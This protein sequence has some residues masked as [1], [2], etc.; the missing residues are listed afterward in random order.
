MNSSELL[1]GVADNRYIEGANSLADPDL[2]ALTCV[3]LTEALETNWPTDA[4]LVCYQLV[5]STAWPRCNKPVLPSIRAAGADLIVPILVFDYDNPNHSDW[6]LGLLE[7]FELRMVEAADFGMPLAMGWTHLYF[8]KHGARLIYVLDH[9]VLA[10]DAEALSL[11]VIRDF[12]AHGIA[13]DSA[14]ADWTRLFRLPRVVRDGEETGSADYFQMVHQAGN[15]LDPASVI[16]GE[17]TAATEYKDLRQLSAP[18]PDP[19]WALDALWDMEAGKG[20]TKRSWWYNQAKSQLRG[21]DCFPVLFEH[22]PLAAPGSRNSKIQSLVGEALAV[23]YPSGIAGTTAEMTFALFFPALDQLNA[24]DLSEPEDFLITGWEA[25]LTYWAREEAKNAAEREVM[26]VQQEQFQKVQTSLLSRIL[27]GV[28]EWCDS[29]PATETEA[30]WWL[31]EHM[32]L[33][34][35]RGFHVM[36]PNGYYDPLGVSKILLPARVRELKIDSLVSLT[37]ERNGEIVPVTGQELIDQYCTLVYSVE[38]AVGAKGSHIKHLGTDRATLV[39]GM[40]ERANIEPEWSPEVDVWLQM[41]AGQKYQDLIDWIAQSLNFEGGPICALSIKGHA[42]SGKKMLVQGLAE[43][44]DTGLIASSAE[45]GRFKALLMHTPFLVVNEGLTYDTHGMHV[46]DTFRHFV[47]GDPLYIEQKF[48][49][50]ILVRNPLRIIFTANNN[51][52]LAT[53]VGGRDLSPEDREAL[54]VRLLHIESDETAAIWL[55]DRGGLEFTKGWIDADDGALG[56]KKIARHFMSLYVNRAP[57]KKGNRLLIQGNATDSLIRMM[58][59]RS[60]TS[61]LVVETLV[62]MVESESILHGL[63]VTNSAIMVTTSA[64]VDFY[65]TGAMGTGSSKLSQSVVSSVLKGLVVPSSASYPRVIKTKAGLKKARW[66]ELD[67]GILLSEA[68]EHGYRCQVLESIVSGKTLKTTVVDDTTKQ[69]QDQW[70][71]QND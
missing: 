11:G 35:A 12:L 7:S 3:S 24:Q 71:S 10:E 22:A 36:Q 1:I 17:R 54:A 4:H 60:G 28:R 62:R 43:C 19:Q 48:K 67:P 26:Q 45:F 64:I 8:T 20:R 16:P 25:I 68:V 70:V 39:H 69:I 27:T 21:R 59:T 49:E 66:R 2:R 33:A 61:P 30:A 52:V 41:L 29:V 46:A 38:G 47:S 58:A 9:A 63:H 56:T 57:M 32:I 34:T 18:L 13:L 6:D 65:R 15:T 53:L 14:C 55:R 40:F 23:L 37:K 5:G 31:S 42:G 50:P 44:I 51:D